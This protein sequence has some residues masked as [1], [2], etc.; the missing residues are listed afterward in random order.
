MMSLETFFVSFFISGVI[1]IVSGA[2]MNPTPSAQDLYTSSA[3]HYIQT[4]G[5]NWTSEG[6][7]A[8]FDAY[9]SACTG[10]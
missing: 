2:V 7:Q 5:D 4:S 9:W 10:K 3:V 1:G 6:Q 8:I